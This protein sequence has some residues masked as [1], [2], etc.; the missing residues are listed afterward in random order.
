MQVG[1]PSRRVPSPVMRNSS[2][3]DTGSLK[4]LR[5]DLEFQ[6]SISFGECLSGVM[7]DVAVPS[8]RSLGFLITRKWYKVL[9]IHSP[10]HSVSCS[11]GFFH[12]TRGTK[13]FKLYYQSFGNDLGKCHGG[14]SRPGSGF[15]QPSVPG[16]EGLGRVDADPQ[17]F[18]ARQFVSKTRFSMEPSQSVLDFIQKETGWSPLTWR[19]L[20]ISLFTRSRGNF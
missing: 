15:L 18:Q 13:K 17:S 10:L 9:F 4:G 3:G 6:P 16:Q 12:P 1:P 14:N 7:E 19:T 8:C 11:S 20:T 2:R 5:K